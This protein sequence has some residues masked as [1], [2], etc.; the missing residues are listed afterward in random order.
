MQTQRDAF[1]D[2]LY[3]EAKNDRDLIIVSA[4]MGAP[5]LDKFRRDYPHQFI[6]TGIAEQNAILV[7]AGLAKEGKRV[8]IY[9]IA[10]FLTLNCVEKIRVQCGMMKIPLNLVGVGAGFSYPD[11]GPTH[12]LIEDLSV[13]RSIPHMNILS[14]ADSTMAKDFA[15][16]Y[17]EFNSPN[18][19]RL[20]RQARP[21]IYSGTIDWELGFNLLKEEGKTVV[22][23]T[24]MMTHMAKTVLEK[25]LQ[26]AHLDL[27]RFPV[28]EAKLSDILTKYQNI[29]TLE[30]HVLAGGLGSYILEIMADHGL[31]K[32]VTRLGIDGRQGYCYQYGGREELWNY[33]GIGEANLEMAIRKYE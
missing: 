26:V 31:T 9:A 25:H 5:S 24:G 14:M 10:S 27:Y 28:N 11:S 6:N 20:E 3:L 4:D 13:M 7:G 22:V 33:C 19:I 15:S 1:W 23:T 16:R 18:Y 30:E 32:N 2:Q 21:T 12:H 29:I 8:F 17:R